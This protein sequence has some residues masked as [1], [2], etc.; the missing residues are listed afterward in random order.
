VDLAGGGARDVGVV[1]DED[2]RPAGPVELEQQVEDLAAG[3]G[4]EI[5]GRLVLRAGSPGP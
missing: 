3:V 4:V 1:G 5:A 2:D